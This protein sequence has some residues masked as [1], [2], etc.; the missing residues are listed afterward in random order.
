MDFKL[1][2]CLFYESLPTL[3]SL[4]MP[5]H[6]GVSFFVCCAS[7]DSSAIHVVICVPTKTRDVKIL[8][9]YQPGDSEQC[10][11]YH[12]TPQGGCWG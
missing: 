1:M 4:E 3:L 11:F 10:V 9:F 7:H 8:D 12:F 2:A 6:Y 5:H